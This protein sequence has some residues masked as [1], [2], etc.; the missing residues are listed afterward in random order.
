MLLALATAL[1]TA[2]ACNV[3]KNGAG[4]VENSIDRVVRWAP[5]DVVR[6]HATSL[7]RRLAICPV[8]RVALRYNAR[9][10]NNLRKPDPSEIEIA[11]SSARI[12]LNWS[13][14]EHRRRSFFLRRRRACG[15]AT[16]FADA[17]E[18]ADDCRRRAVGVRRG[19]GN[20]KWFK[21]GG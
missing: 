17:L 18:S 8:G 9:M 12:R 3:A 16:S 6:R 5:A 15:Q 21:T 13:A 1:F 19:A 4:G 11:E 14:A 7:L 20:Q 10:V 2:E